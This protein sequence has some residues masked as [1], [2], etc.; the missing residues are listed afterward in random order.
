MPRF[1]FLLVTIFFAVHVLATPL[2]NV[3][4][5]NRAPQALGALYFT[6]PVFNESSFVKYNC[7]TNDD[8]PDGV[9][10]EASSSDSEFG[11]CAQIPNPS[12]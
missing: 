3:N 1:V 6:D 7:K 9:S 5:Y 4:S 10:C 11:A 12:L 8:C 2:R